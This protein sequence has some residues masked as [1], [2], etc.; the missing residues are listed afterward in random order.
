MGNNSDTDSEKILATVLEG[1][2]R[3]CTG[4]ALPG[5][6]ACDVCVCVCAGMCVGFT[7]MCE[8]GCSGKIHDLK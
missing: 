3:P 5:R 6:C 7:G 8:R 4:R 2:S 1:N